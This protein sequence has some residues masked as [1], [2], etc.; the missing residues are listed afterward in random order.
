MADDPGERD[1]RMR[2]L[3][4]FWGGDVPESTADRIVYRDIR[5]EVILR[6]IN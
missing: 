6:S 4:E 1:A 5:S 3:E 2:A